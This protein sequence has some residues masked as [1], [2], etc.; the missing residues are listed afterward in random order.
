MRQLLG[1]LNLQLDFNSY[2]IGDLAD[3]TAWRTRSVAVFL[4]S[5]RAAFVVSYRPLPI[6]WVSR[7]GRIFSYTFEL[8]CS[9]SHTSTASCI[10]IHVDGSMLNSRPRR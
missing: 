3:L 8:L 9:V 2:A 7:I 5:R 4:A 10:R 1:Q 6:G